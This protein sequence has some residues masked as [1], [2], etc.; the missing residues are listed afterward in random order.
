MRPT[1]D[2]EHEKQKIT[3]L[4]QLRLKN[5]S[6]DPGCHTANRLPMPGELLTLWTLTGT[7]RES[8]RLD[9]KTNHDD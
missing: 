1:P 6:T 8:S 9:T 4:K 5:N 2:A 3:G 7:E